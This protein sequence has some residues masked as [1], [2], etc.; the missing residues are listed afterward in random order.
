MIEGTSNPFGSI[1]VANLVRKIENRER[2][3]YKVN[4]QKKFYRGDI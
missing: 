2:K 3:G 4:L 1:W